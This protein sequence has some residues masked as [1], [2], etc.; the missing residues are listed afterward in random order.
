MEFYSK[1]YIKIA[2]RELMRPIIRLILRNG[3]MYRDFMQIC[4]HLYVEIAS[5]EYG[6]KGRQT[7]ISRV[8]LLTGLDRKEVKRVRGL[9][10]ENEP[11]N[12]P[13]QHSADRISRILTGW[14]RDSAYSTQDLPKVLP[15]DGDEASFS[16]LVRK[17]GSDV[18]ATTMLKEFIRVGVVEQEGNTVRALKSY[19]IPDTENLNAIHRMGNVIGDITSTLYHNFYRDNPDD[20]QAHFERCATNLEIDP[21]NVTLFH[22][23]LNDKGQKFLED[24]DGWLSEHEVKDKGS[25]DKIRLGVGAYWIQGDNTVE[26]IK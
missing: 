22:E 24:I 18:P 21:A 7:N 14:H 19:Y 5:Q 6:V 10:E 2:F 11:Q 8:A 3:L 20:T 25:V 9:L 15:I 16:S 26:A 12:I 4:K 23:Y 1:K 17:Y 13:E